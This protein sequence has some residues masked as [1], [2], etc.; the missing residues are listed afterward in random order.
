MA[1]FINR[2]I[3]RAAFIWAAVHE[4]IFKIRSSD[5]TCRVQEPSASC[6]NDWRV[7]QGPQ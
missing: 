5:W 1:N 2:Q 4:V 3:H 7:K 6:G